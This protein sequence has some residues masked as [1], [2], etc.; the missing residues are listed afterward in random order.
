MLQCDETRPAC[1]KCKQ[2]AVIC[3]YNGAATS[4]LIDNGSASALTK[5]VI[6]PTPP[7]QRRKRGRPRKHFPMPDAKLSPESSSTSIRQDNPSED[8]LGVYDLRLLHHFTVS[9]ASTLAGS[10]AT[11]RVEHFWRVS[12]PE[13]AFSYAF[14][15][16][17]VLSVSAVHLGRVLPQEQHMQQAER[18]FS[19][20]L[21]Q[22]RMELGVPGSAH[23]SAALWI[24][25]MLVCY[26][27]LGQG[28]K[29][30]NYLC[31]GDEGAT[32]WM[33]LLRGCR[34][35]REQMGDNIS[36]GP[37]AGLFGRGVEAG[38]VDLSTDPPDSLS[39]TLPPMRRTNSSTR[40]GDYADPLSLLRQFIEQANQPCN[41]EAFEVL[42]PCYEA[43]FADG[44]VR[45]GD[46]NATVF[47]WLWRVS[48]E[49]TQ[50]LFQEKPHALVI[51]SYFI[52]LLNTLEIDHWFMEGWSRH[53]MQGI[54]AALPMKY[55]KWLLWPM[56]AI[57]YEPGER[58]ASLS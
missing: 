7:P 4:R 16:R 37:L 55:W 50:L 17:I 1:L 13:L 34:A 43:L 42:I 58:L 14:L 12:V 5:P 29:P 20:G 53:V 38:E 52:V 56:Q 18:H 45:H 36:T 46:H 44:E 6:E 51:Y 24:S 39:R 25:S 3:N 57:G 11:R 15:L 28:P 23:K 21:E 30:G 49:Y 9:T 22:M 35:I 10:L 41:I 32:R 8:V 33:S 19:T 27:T 48:D 40:I 31:F 2:H 47:V 54:E 26:Y